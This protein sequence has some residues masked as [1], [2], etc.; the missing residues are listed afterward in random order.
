MHVSQLYAC[1]DISKAT[2]NLNQRRKIHGR[3]TAPTNVNNKGV[4]I[5][6]D[7]QNGKSCVVARALKAAKL[8]WLEH[9]WFH[10][11]FVLN[12]HDDVPRGS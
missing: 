7:L 3:L 8:L 6:A 5:Y 9:R 1:P 10:G 11:R 12:K 4:V 2:A